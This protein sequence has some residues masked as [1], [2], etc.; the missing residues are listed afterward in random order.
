ME[1]NHTC[2]LCRIELDDLC[3]RQGGQTLLQ[4]VNLHIHCG[5]L[6]ALIGHNGAGKTTLL[7]ALLGQVPYTGRIAHLDTEGSAMSR[8]RIGY[9]PQQLPFDRSMPLTVQDYLA[10][11]LTRRPVWTGVSKRVREQVREAL[12]L[13]EAE[14]LQRATLGKL[15][16]G[17]LQRVLL[18][19]ALT[20]APDLLLLDEPVSGVDQN[21]QMLFL[22]RVLALR[23]ERHMGI[24]LISHD[25]SLVSRYADHVALLNKTILCQGSPDEVFASDAFAGQFATPSHQPCRRAE[26][27][28]CDCCAPHADAADPAPK[29]AE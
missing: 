9:V 29:E 2:R 5:Q 22:D 6:T 7:R 18:S 24:L 19:L 1:Q 15:S 23:R 8:V 28:C 10:S 25:F 14:R 4:D 16:G 27:G 3:V 26:T 21:G 13:S 17:E 11:A 12:A 20:P